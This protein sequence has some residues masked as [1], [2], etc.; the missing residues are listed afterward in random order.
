MAYLYLLNW[1][2]FNLTLVFLHPVLSSLVTLFYS[3]GRVCRDEY[4][5]GT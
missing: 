3:P 2:C 4:Y 5:I 1:T